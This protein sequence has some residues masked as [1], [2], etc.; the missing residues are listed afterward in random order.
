MNVNSAIEY[1]LPKPKNNSLV[2]EQIIDFVEELKPDGAMLY[3]LNFDGMPEVVTWQ[4]NYVY[5]DTSCEVYSIQS[6]KPKSVLKFNIDENSPILLY[7]NKDNSEFFYITECRHYGMANMITAY[8]E[9]HTV[10]KNGFITSNL[11]E[12][13][14]Y[15]SNPEKG[16]YIYS[17]SVNGKDVPM[18]GFF[19]NLEGGILSKPY[20]NELSKYLSS[21]EKIAEI[22]LASIL[23]SAHWHTTV[24]RNS[25]NSSSYKSYPL[26]Y[27]KAPEKN[28]ETILLN[29]EEIPVNTTNCTLIINK[30]GIDYSPLKKLKNL[31]EFRVMA[32]TD[33]T[34]FSFE[35]LYDLRQIT[36]LTIGFDYDYEL[37]KN[38]THKI[39]FDLPKISKMINLEE[40]C[41]AA[42]NLN[43]TSLGF[44]SKNT[45]LKILRI[46]GNV[47]QSDDY[48]APIYSLPN[49]ELIVAN[50][51]A[52]SLSEYQQNKL[53]ENFDDLI[54]A[55]PK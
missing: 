33:E 54:I 45:A 35:Y 55:F 29:G 23:D 40:I 37:K 34:N 44:L 39:D 32:A 3:D 17:N 31:T 22:N 42:T 21:Y 1:N 7:K 49:I 12:S 53:L 8:A 24:R 6:G 47:P 10:Y 48:F 43:I 5:W 27:Y 2:S 46:P 19:S 41:I 28:D 26:P 51:M 18:Q 50:G 13:E 14:I 36:S 20:Q 9:K 25:V 4:N 52:E 15:Y 11:A 38:G 30:P 16:C